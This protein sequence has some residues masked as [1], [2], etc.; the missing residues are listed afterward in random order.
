MKVLK[1][2][3]LIF[4]ILTVLSCQ[5][6]EKDIEKFSKEL[7]TDLINQD[8]LSLYNKQ[9]DGEITG[10]FGILDYLSAEDNPTSP[11]DFIKMSKKNYDESK[12]YHLV[13]FGGLTRSFNSSF[14]S[15]I[16]SYVVENLVLEDEYEVQ[17]MLSTYLKRKKQLRF[18]RVEIRIKTESGSEYILNPGFIQMLDNELYYDRL[19][20]NLQKI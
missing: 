7:V 18:Y 11:S 17:D 5:K 2:L 16:K 14:D 13:R 20:F 10:R 15:S 4:L 9:M 12:A 1:H 6:N 3:A 8:S 19:R